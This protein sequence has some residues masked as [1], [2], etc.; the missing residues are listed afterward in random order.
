MP[1]RRH[2]AAEA[3][4][5]R[6]AATTVFLPLGS[7]P[8]FFTLAPP[9]HPGEIKTC[10]ISVGFGVVPLESGG[11]KYSIERNNPAAPSAHMQEPGEP[12][13]VAATRAS[14]PGAHDSR[15]AAALSSAAVSTAGA[16]PSAPSSPSLPLPLPPL[17]PLKAPA[18]PAPS[19]AHTHT[20]FHSS[21]AAQR[22][23]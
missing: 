12:P 5:L 21:T 4:K 20:S 2:R 17:P 11:K 18:P 9:T 19:T 14:A 8:L 23:A 16:T 3:R 10:W 15:H 13:A 1:R 22:S 7:A 6:G